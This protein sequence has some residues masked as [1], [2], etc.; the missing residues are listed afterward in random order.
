MA[1][2]TA[3]KKRILDAA[4]ELF[5]ERGFAHTSLRTITAKAQVNAAAVNY[6]F[7][8]KDVLIEKD[9]TT[10][11]PLSR[12]KED[13]KPGEIYLQDHGNPLWFRNIW[14]APKGN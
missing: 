14:V 12:Q 6:Y 1:E 8:S 9:W 13:P 11:S 5:A 3:T 4:E 10:A 7:G 2:H